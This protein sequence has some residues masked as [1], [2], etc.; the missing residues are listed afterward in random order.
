MG[1]LEEKLVRIL[2]RGPMNKNDLVA[3]IYSDESKTL[4]YETILN[5]FKNLLARVRKK[6][7]NLI[8]FDGKRYF[9]TAEAP[10]AL[11]SNAV[12]TSS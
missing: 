5:R 1:V 7:P 6:A 12:G 8:V 11:L 4:D 2:A 10:S 3:V 9:L